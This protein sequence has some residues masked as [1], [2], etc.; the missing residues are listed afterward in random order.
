MLT[1]EIKALAERYE[2][3]A[4]SIR[5]TLHKIPETEFEEFKTSGYIASVLDTLSIEYRRGFA[6]G[7]GIC[8]TI[9]GKGEGRCVAIRAD[10][11]ALPV[12][13]ETY[14][15]FASEHEGRMHACGHDAHIA[16]ALFTAFILNELHDNFKGNVKILFQP[17]EE[18]EGGAERMI[19]EG[20]L[21]SPAVDVCIGGHVMSDYEAG[22]II[23]KKGP[24]MASPDNFE[25]IIKGAGGHG[26]YPQ[27]CINPI[28]AAAAAVENITKLTDMNVP[29]AVSVCTI[30][31]GSCSNVIPSEVKIT[32]TARTFTPEERQKVSRLIEEAV[33][34]A[35]EPLGAEYDYRFI[36]LFPALINDDRITDL[37]AEAARK[38]AGEENVIETHS[39]SMAGDDFSYFA[40]ARP[41]SYIHIGCRNEE[42]GAVYPIHSPKFILDERCIKTAAM[43][44]A[45]FAVDYLNYN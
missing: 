38:T 42:I 12:K 24:L 15:P 9:P 39:L 2:E 17:A 30:K 45:Q 43:C 41:S 18:G 37:L 40:K 20:V 10:I 36:P 4:I 1:N 11:D 28:S 3:T 16:I 35:A 7:T 19:D 8:A 23:Y 5:R 31:G 22:K 25:A 13:E 14:L 29:R 27:K 32:G 21:A 26:A 6:G 44:Y 34:S 33:R